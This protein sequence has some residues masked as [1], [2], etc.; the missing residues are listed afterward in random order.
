MLT[1]LLQRL[2]AGIRNAVSNVYRA[3]SQRALR[4]MLMFNDHLL[5][6]IGLTRADVIDCLSTP[7]DD[8][9]I[10]FL[11]ARRQRNTSIAEPPAPGNRRLAA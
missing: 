8:D 1:L 7:S 6:D 9:L 10:D 5:R 3:R 4:G 2:A 11:N